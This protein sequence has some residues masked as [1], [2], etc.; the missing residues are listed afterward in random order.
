MLVIRLTRVGK[1][2]KALFRLVVQEKLRAPSSKAL[3]IVGQYNPHTDPGTV[4][5]KEERIK[6]WIEHGAQPSAT[7]HNLLVNAKL[8]TG[9]KKKAVKVKRKPEEKT[10]A[11]QTAPA[12]AAKDAKPEKT[13]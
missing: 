12:P 8:I 7:V 6:Y 1:R 9:P 5:L 10:A 4:T 11:S 13:A 3:E 2:N